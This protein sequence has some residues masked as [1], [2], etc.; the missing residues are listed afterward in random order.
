MTVEQLPRG[1]AFAGRLAAHGDRPALLTDRGALTYTELAERVSGFADSLGRARRL[2]LVSARNDVD[3]VTA[4]LGAL[5]GDHVVLLAADSDEGVDAL[6]AAYDPDVVVRAGGVEERRTGSA[7][8]LHPDL[9][10]L[11][12]TSGTTGSPR[13][14]RLGAAGVQ[15]NA[16]SIAEYLAVRDSDVAVTTMPLHYC[17]GLSVLHSHLLRGAAVLLSDLS[18]VDACFWEAVDRHGVTSIAGVPYTFEQLERAGFADRSVPSLRYLTQA[19]GRMPAERVRRFAELGQR[20]GFDLFVMYGQTEATARMAYLPPDLAH[21][22]P[23]AVGVAIPGGSLRVDAPEGEVGELVYAGPNVMLG[24][25]AS[26]ADLARGRETVELR[27]GDLARVNA[28]GLVEVVGRA[29][30]FAKVFGLRVDLERV[31][32]LLADDGLTACCTSDDARLFVAVEGVGERGV[33]RRVAARVAGATGLPP[34]AVA[35]VTVADLPRLPSGKVDTATVRSLAAAA[36]AEDAAPVGV[37]DTFALVL[38]RD[39]VAPDDTFVSLGGD[40]LSYVEASVRLEQLLGE[41]PAQWHLQTVAQLEETRSRGGGGGPP[42]P[43]GRGGP[44]RRLGA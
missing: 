44:A 18:V 28:A 20:R 43:A 23:A 2:V 5:A 31:E 11:L 34:V 25:A 38:G 9:S 33:L 29:A 35:V 6:V 26:P 30:R 17:Y 39:A 15:A 10:L 7:H 3:T 40:S 1:V 42:P 27:T 36:R 8:E 22:H 13:L 12:S 32:Q 14:V 19:G 41:L 37:A 4:H 24:Y 21:A 16:E